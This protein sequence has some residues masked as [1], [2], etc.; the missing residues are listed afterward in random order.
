MPPNLRR[1][2]SLPLAVVVDLFHPCPPPPPSLQDEDAEYEQLKKDVVA[3]T[4]RLVLEPFIIAA[5]AAVGLNFGAA[6]RC[7]ALVCTGR[8]HVFY[9]RRSQAVGRCNV[10]FPIGKEVKFGVFQ[11]VACLHSLAF[12]CL[13]YLYLHWIP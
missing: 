5:A 13:G 11:V 1:V 12:I 9:S 8:C 3:N 7:V 10:Y 6:M 2:S 4:R